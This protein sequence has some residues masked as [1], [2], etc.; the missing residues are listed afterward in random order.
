MENDVPITDHEEERLIKDLI[1]LPEQRRPIY[2]KLMIE[3]I[4]KRS[5]KVRMERYLNRIFF[6]IDF[7]NALPKN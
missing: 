2:L 1:R 4:H 6:R 5:D 3:R 7:M